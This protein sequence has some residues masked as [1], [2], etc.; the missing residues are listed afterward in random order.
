MIVNGRKC[1]FGSYNW[2]GSAESSGSTCSKRRQREGAW[3]IDGDAVQAFTEKPQAEDKFI[4][5]EPII[6]KMEEVPV[7]GKEEAGNRAVSKGCCLTP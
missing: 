1:V 3:S 5:T 4:L 6:I 2:S 7:F